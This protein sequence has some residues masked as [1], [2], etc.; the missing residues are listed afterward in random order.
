MLTTVYTDTVA[1]KPLLSRFWVWMV[2]PISPENIG[3]LL[4]MFC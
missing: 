2:E 4:S 3:D 1:L